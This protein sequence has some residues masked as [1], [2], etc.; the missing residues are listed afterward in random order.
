MLVNKKK[1]KSLRQ[2]RNLTQEALATQCGLNSRTIQRVERHGVASNDTVAAYCAVFG[3]GPDEILL[4]E[5]QEERDQFHL[6]LSPIL[7]GV[8]L[9]FLLGITSAL[10]FIG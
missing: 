3:I 8:I 10:V 1:V 4:T 9:G 6:P 7:C 2:T 5:S